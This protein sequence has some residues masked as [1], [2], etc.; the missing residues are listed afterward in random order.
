VLFFLKEQAEKSKKLISD[1]GPAGQIKIMVAT[2][3]PNLS[4]WE[5][6]KNV[7]FL[8]SRSN[9]GASKADEESLIPEREPR[10]SSQ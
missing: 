6:S 1:T 4:V 8:K 2:H 7:V 10:Y 9:R 3:S 5:E